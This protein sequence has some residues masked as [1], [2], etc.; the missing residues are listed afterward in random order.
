MTSPTTVALVSFAFILLL[1]ACTKKEDSGVT[2]SNRTVSTPVVAAPSHIAAGSLAILI[3]NELHTNLTHRT[4]LTAD[5]VYLVATS[6]A[7]SLS[8][9]KLALLG[10][11]ADSSQT[12]ENSIELFT[13]ELVQGAVRALGAL[14]TV[15]PVHQRQLNQA[16]AEIVASLMGSLEGRSSHLETTPL[17]QLLFTLAERA[18]TTLDEAG[19]SVTSMAEAARLITSAAIGALDDA[20]VLS[21][22]NGEALITAIVKRGDARPEGKPARCVRQPRPRLQRCAR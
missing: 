15:G 6:A 3:V 5:Q 22:T 1:N 19:Y 20:G 17:G 11:L 21:P 18:M 8:L 9:E 16:L 4:S 14:G 10:D 12:Y 13:D 2:R 7:G